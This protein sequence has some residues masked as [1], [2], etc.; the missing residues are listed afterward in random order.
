MSTTHDAHG[1]ADWQVPAYAVNA[2]RPKQSR[3]CVCIFVINEGEKIKKQLRNMQELSKTIDVI[4]ADGGSTDGSLAPE[5]IKPLGV[6][7]LLTKTGPGKLSAQMRM[8]FAYAMKQGYDGVI[9]IDG[10]G[11]DDPSAIPDFVKALDDG[12]DHIQGSRFIPGGKSVNLPFSR[13]F[14]ITFIHAPLISIASRFRYTDTTNGFRAYSKQLL[15][16][17]NVAPFRD[18]FSHYELHYYM[19]IRAA[20]LGFKVKELPVTRQYPSDG[21]IPTKI[22]PLKGNFLVLRTLFAAC[23]GRFNP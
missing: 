19:A 8:A 2:F 22:S 7:T 11:K 21:P 16:D 20:R 14:G 9:T 1:T 3:Y 18:I 13:W 23:A 12:F 15:L 4:I 10:N 17:K 5:I 6:H